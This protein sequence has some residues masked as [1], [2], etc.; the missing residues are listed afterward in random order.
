MK[1]QLKKILPE[2]RIFVS[3]KAISGILG[4]TYCVNVWEFLYTTMSDNPHVNHNPTLI[5]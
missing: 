1:E 5:G 2:N 4:K 3:N